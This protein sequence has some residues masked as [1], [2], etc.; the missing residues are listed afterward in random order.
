MQGNPSIVI[1]AKSPRENPETYHYQVGGYAFALNRQQDGNPVQYIVATNGVSLYLWHWDSN[2]PELTMSFG[3]FEE[4]NAK[5]VQLRSLL[6]YRAVDV[7]RA[8]R[9]VFE[10]ERPD[11]NELIRVFNECHYHNMEER[12]IGTQLMLSI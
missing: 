10:F 9:D 7:I 4:D 1:D 5:F 8:T 6:A 3:D 11:L 2:T 12:S